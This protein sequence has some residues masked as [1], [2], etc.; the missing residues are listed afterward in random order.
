MIAGQ[1]ANRAQLK[2]FRDRQ[3]SDVDASEHRAVCS[4]DGPFGRLHAF[5]ARPRYCPTQTRPHDCD[6]AHDAS[7][8]IETAEFADPI[9]HTRIPNDGDVGLVIDRT[10]S[11]R[12]HGRIT[13]A[14]NATENLLDELSLA[15]AVFDADQRLINNN[16][17]YSRMWNLPQDWL[18]THPM[19]GEILDRLRESRLLP[20][21]RDFAGWKKV[22]LKQFGAGRLNIVDFWHV[23]SG[24]SLR[25]V[26]Q[27]RPQ[28]GLFVTYEDVSETLALK[29][30][31]AALVAVQIATLDALDEAVAIFKPDGRLSQS[32][33]AFA[34]LWRLSDAELANEPHFSEI[35]ALCAARTGRDRTWDIVS[36]A[37]GCLSLEPTGERDR[38]TRTDGKV[39]SVTAARLPNGATLVSFLDLTDVG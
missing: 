26:S 33:R 18:N 23:P 38:V 29:A 31:N 28:G 21:Q 19:L 20:E 14:T 34:S 9:P 17:S 37:V 6:C 8:A 35:E 15:I 16:S 24:Q 4:F 1:S 2:L 39:I 22:Y 25:V 36:S 11:M 10:I 32:N 13:I 30:S 12:R 7:R 27:S 3:S 5:N